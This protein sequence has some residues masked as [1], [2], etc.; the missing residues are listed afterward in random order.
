LP[1]RTDNEIKNYWNSHLRRRA[2][3]FSSCGDGVVVNVDLS[4]MPGG[5]KRR[6]G[7]TGRG[8]ATTKGGKGKEKKEKEKNTNVPTTSYQPCH[9]QSEEHSASGVTSDGLEDGPLGLSEEMVSGLLGPCMDHD[10]SGLRMDSDGGSGPSGDVAQDLGKNEALEDWDLSGLDISVDDD[11]WDSLVWDYDNM[12]LV[13]EEG[14]QGE[15]MPDL[16]FLD[17]MLAGTDSSTF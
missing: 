2:S 3:D 1:G 9:A 12:A 17:N 6:G 13:P 15:V 8:A 11:M 5:G 14:Q 16:F 7:R 4:K 10:S